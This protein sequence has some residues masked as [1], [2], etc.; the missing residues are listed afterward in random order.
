MTAGDVRWLIVQLRDFA[1]YYETAA[2]EPE[3]RAKYDRDHK[4]CLRLAS[5]LEKQTKGE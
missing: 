1:S 3:E 2:C 4:R 5:L